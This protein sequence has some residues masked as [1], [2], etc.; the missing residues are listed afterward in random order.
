MSR[1]L[2]ENCTTVLLEQTQVY[3]KI[4]QLTLLLLPPESNELLMIIITEGH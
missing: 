1:P 2:A 4:I 3:M